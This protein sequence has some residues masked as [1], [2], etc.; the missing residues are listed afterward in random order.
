MEAS[1]G[2]RQWKEAEQWKQEVEESSGSKCVVEA[3]KQ[4]SGSKY[5]VEAE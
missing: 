4:S 2:N 3:R 5:I 1:I